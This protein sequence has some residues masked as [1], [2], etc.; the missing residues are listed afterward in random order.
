MKVLVAYGTTEGHT[1][2]V[3]ETI[4]IQIKQLGHEVELFHT[5]K[6]QRDLQFNSFDKIILAGS[7]HQKDYQEFLKLFIEENLSVLNIKPTM[8]ISVS[9]ASAFDD[10]LDEAIGYTSKLTEQLGWS[11]TKILLIAGA[12]KYDKYDYFKEQIIKH[13][14]LQGH[15]VDLKE[16]NQEFTDWSELAANV[17]EFISA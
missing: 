16:G 5:E 4:S 14:A 17:D 6:P 8:L 1:R 15:S 11:P 2:K 13:I 3:A 9:L 7:V 12:I 10:R